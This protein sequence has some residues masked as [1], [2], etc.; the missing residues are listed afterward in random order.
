MVFVIFKGKMLAPNKEYYFV[1]L[2]GANLT[3]VARINFKSHGIYYCSL[4]SQTFKDIIK[5]IENFDTMLREHL[6]D[7]KFF[8]V[9]KH[10][11]ILYSEK[12]SLLNEAVYFL[13]LLQPSCLTLWA[14]FHTYWIEYEDYPVAGSSLNTYTTSGFTWY[15]SV[16]ELSDVIFKDE[17]TELF[18]LA[19]K[20]APFVNILFKK[21]LYSQKPPEF[22]QTIRIYIQA[23][24]ESRPYI[25]YITLMIIIESLIISDETQGVSYKIRRLCAVLLGATIDECRNLFEK[26]KKAYEVRSKYVHNAQ[27]KLNEGNFLKFIHSVV[28]ELMIYIIAT[29]FAAPKQNYFEWSNEMGYGSRYEKITDKKLKTFPHLFMNELNFML[30]L[31]RK[32]KR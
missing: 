1:I 18:Y 8:Q 14:E 29:D 5:Q 20:E 12:E 6:G 22:V 13:Q 28:S 26:M 3:S 27:Y 25:K 2:A 30:D 4:R 10:A 23:F 15:M 9:D 7:L 11:F 31:V 24:E 19:K 21:Y 32:K 16:A 17:A